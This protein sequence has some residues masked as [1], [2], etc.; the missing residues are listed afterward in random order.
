MAQVLT[1]VIMVALSLAVPVPYEL[2]WL[3][4]GKEPFPAAWLC[5]SPAYGPYLVWSGFG[6]VQ[7]RDSGSLHY[8]LSHGPWRWYCWR[9]SFLNVVWRRDSGQTVPKSRLLAGG[10]L[11][12]ELSPGGENAGPGCYL[13]A[14]SDGLWNRIDEQFRWAG[15]FSLAPDWSVLRLGDRREVLAHTDEFC[16]YRS[17]ISGGNRVAAAFCGRPFELQKARH[18]GAFEFLLTTPL[19]AKNS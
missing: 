13:P 15:S 4:N 10:L 7:S 3:L 17:D 16:D 18:S 6:T 5:L 12:R 8:S 9:E 1:V 19:T 2:G 14:H 11:T